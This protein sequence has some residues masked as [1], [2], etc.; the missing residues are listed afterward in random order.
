VIDDH[1]NNIMS[2]G[3]MD[4]T[5]ERISKYRNK[6]IEYPC[7]CRYLFDHRI[8]LERI[9]TEHENELIAHHGWCGITQ[10]VEDAW[11]F[12]YSVAYRS[13]RAVPIEPILIVSA[14]P[15][16]VLGPHL[17][18]RALWRCSNIEGF[19]LKFHKH[20][21][22]HQLLVQFFCWFPIPLIPSCTVR[23]IL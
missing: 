5:T 18:P 4:Q 2:S 10:T 6:Y 8:V 15:S 19:L 20:C 12:C 23:T 21:I 11:G 17:R 3:V 1:H 14:V 22:W 16:I 9:C 13:N 7:G